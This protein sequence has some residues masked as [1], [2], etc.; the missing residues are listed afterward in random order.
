MKQRL[1]AT[2]F[3]ADYQSLRAMRHALQGA[4]KLCDPAAQLHMAVL[5]CCSELATNF[6][7]HSSDFGRF[8]L[9]LDI[10]DQQLTMR[11]FAE[12]NANHR[13]PLQTWLNSLTQTSM[14]DLNFERSGGRGASLIHE[15]CPQRDIECHSTGTGFLNGFRL[16][17]PLPVKPDRPILLLLEDDAAQR[18][19]YQHY[20]SEYFTVHSCADVNEAIHALASTQPD[21]IVSDLHLPQHS[22]LDFRCY[23]NHHESFSALPF[24]FLSAD[25]KALHKAELIRSGYD[26]YLL[27][28]V[29]KAALLNHTEQLL[30]RSKQIRAVLNQQYTDRIREA[31]KPELAPNF[32]NWQF[33]WEAKNT[34]H[35]GGDLLFA[36][37]EQDALVIV[38]LDLMGHD[39][40]AKFFSY[41]YLGYLR[42]WLAAQ[43]PKQN[44]ASMLNALSQAIHSDRLL[45]QTLC[46]ALVLRLYPDG[47]YE[48]ANAGH[49]CALLVSATNC[50]PVGESGTL[51]GLHPD[52]RYAVYQGDIHAGERMALFTDGLFEHADP[53]AKTTEKAL[54]QWLLESHSHSLAESCEHVFSRLEQGNHGIY[55]DDCLLLLIDRRIEQVL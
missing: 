28:P 21:I 46:T 5:T 2:E 55:R 6:L 9:E 18:S 52:I 53:L 34:G 1:I 40:D 35:G 7:E 50:R 36:Y 44:P 22:G 41:A 23:L 32:G 4:L 13:E 3:A 8:C 27:K 30:T 43:T 38:L 17:W 24:L 48:C 47:R 26:A 49:P 16:S 51:A 42:G 31:L 20:L 25:S 11:L 33:H 15:L 19:L 45:S 37:E 54:Q 12:Q 14:A 39:V 29:T 10:E